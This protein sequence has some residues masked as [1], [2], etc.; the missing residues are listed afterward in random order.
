[1][2]RLKHILAE[3][4]E[5]SATPY[6]YN[7]YNGEA[8]FETEGGT[9]YQVSFPY[10]SDEGMEIAFATQNSQGGWDHDVETAESDV[11]RVMSTIVEIARKAVEKWRPETVVF[12]VA[13]SDPRRMRLYRAYVLRAL[14]GYSISQET[15]SYMELE[16]DGGSGTQYDWT[17]IKDKA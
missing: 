13:K 15:A 5:A 9:M 6:P 10:G 3:I 12:G 16:R 1:M 17:G 14:R 4:G 8:Y 7:M 11:Y 2:I